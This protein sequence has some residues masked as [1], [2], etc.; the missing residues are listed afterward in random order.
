MKRLFFFSSLKCFTL[1]IVWGLSSSVHADD[2]SA[3][4][5]LSVL[6]K[7]EEL[8][9][10]PGSAHILNEKDLKD[11][12]INDIHRILRS[13]PGVNIQE[14]DGYG[15]R[16]NIGLRGAHPHRSKSITLMEDGVLIAP[17]PYAA[18]AAYYFPQMDKM[19]SIE[20]FKGAPSTQFGP[21]SIGG[22][23]NMLTRIN[24][25]GAQFGISRGSYG[26][27][28][29]D[30]SL[31]IQTFGDITLDFTRMESTGFKE[32]EGLDNTGFV[33]NNFMGR[34]DK[35]FSL[36]EQNLTFKFNWSTETSNETYTGITREDFQSNALQ[37]YRSTALD[38]MDW[39]HRQFMASY[40]LSPWTDLR[41]RTTA[42]YHE[43][44]RD[45]FKLN[46]FYAGGTLKPPSMNEILRNPDFAANNHYYRVL[47]GDSNS[48]AL[49]SQRDVLDLGNNNRVYSS[50][51]V[52]THWTYELQGFAS[53][54]VFTVGY[55]YHEDGVDRYHDST[56][57]NMQ[58]RNLVLNSNLGTVETVRNNSS[59]NA[60]TLV[61]SYESQWEKLNYNAAVR[62]EDIRYEQTDFMNS[63]VQQ[64]TNSVFAPGAGIY[65]Q[66][67]DSLGV[68]A[69]VSRGFTPVGPGQ[70]SNIQPEEA[71][72]Y[73][74]GMRYTGVVSGELIGFY[75]DYQNI[76]G[77]C[78]L[79]NGCDPTLVDVSFNGGKAHIAGAEFLLHKE[80]IFGTWSLPLRWSATYT[81]AYFK[82]NFQS[83]LDEWGIGA[84]KSG[85]PLP[86]VPRWQSNINLGLNWQGLFSTLNLNYQSKTADQAMEFGREVI[87]ER[88]V[89][90]LVVGYNFTGNTSLR[91]RVDNLTNERYPV[92][93]RP[94]GLR[95]GMPQSF[96]VGLTHVFR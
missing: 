21:N 17:A 95:P 7:K 92:S 72:N 35:Y 22:A 53:S 87:R 79:S 43:M 93:I 36:M 8:P 84:I 42:Y 10:R 4:E 30:A 77:T 13:V 96:I 46:G 94:F 34:W 49:S 40:A 47:R 54:H 48:G 5:K 19:A 51:G 78:S 50:Q 14:E 74:I 26:F 11:F 52:Q 41:I 3:V 27:Q 56:Y 29:Y 60:Q 37:R 28:K 23:I 18:P 63:T 68:L 32:L 31:G 20:V 62:Y 81:E 38:K 91:L 44:D 2:R 85:D 16:P 61:F 55:R 67:L 64:S 58:D 59:A 76:L 9:T 88:W 75:S 1:L 25:P 89:T 69:G 39:L 82:N 15:L 73:E 6:G 33:R 45:W 86:Y 70:N 66:W 57:Y 83:G 90:D 12:E 80:L 24:E 65:Y 71:T